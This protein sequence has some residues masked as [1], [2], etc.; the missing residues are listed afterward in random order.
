MKRAAVLLCLLSLAACGSPSREDVDERKRESGTRELNGKVGV[1]LDEG[2]VYYRYRYLPDS[3]VV[4]GEGLEEGPEVEMPFD[5]FS[6]IVV[7]LEA[8][9]VVIAEDPA[10]MKYDRM[11]GED[12]VIV[13]VSVPPAAAA[14]LGGAAG[15]ALALGVLLWAIRRQRRERRLQR[16]LARAREAERA[17]LAREIHDGPLQ[18]LCAL[19]MGLVG[20]GDQPVDTDSARV[21]AAEIIGEL[22][23]VCG[24]LRPPG[25]DQMGLVRS[26]EALM[27]RARARHPEIAFGF[28]ASPEAEALGRDLGDEEALA[29]FRIAQEALTNAIQHASASRIEVAAEASGGAIRLVVTDNGVGLERRK[30]QSLAEA[31]HFGIVGMKERANTL[32]L[33]LAFRTPEAGGTQ[34]AVSRRRTSSLQLS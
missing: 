20:L 6:A 24:A 26:V 34:V 21:L 4:L 7:Q 1:F 5:A 10:A 25:L 30:D 15:L 28:E 9:G 18:E 31:G 8:L 19:Q 2:P 13:S 29:L 14:A 3:L 22:R 16:G 11:P 23:L 32:D 33:R 12:D 17:H 27:E